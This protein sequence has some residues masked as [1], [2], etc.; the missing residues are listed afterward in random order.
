M[1]ID[2]DVQTAAD[3]TG[4]ELYTGRQQVAGDG[5]VSGNTNGSEMGQE[6]DNDA[7]KRHLSPVTLAAALKSGHCVL[8]LGGSS[9]RVLSA[10]VL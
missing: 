8:L 10:F 9:L 7:V 5:D 3:I 6:A 1:V 4:E 2:R